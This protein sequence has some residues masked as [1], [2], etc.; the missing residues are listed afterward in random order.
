MYPPRTFKVVAVVLKREAAAAAAALLYR[1]DASTPFNE[2]QL[3]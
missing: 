2:Y 3:Q 1:I